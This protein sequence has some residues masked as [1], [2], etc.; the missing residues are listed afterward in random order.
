MVLDTLHSYFVEPILNNG[1]F[2]PVNTLVYAIILIIAVFLVYRL[3]RRMKVKIDNHFFLAII[4]FI[5][6]ASSTRVLHDAAVAGI[7]SPELNQ[8][9]GMLIFPTPGSYIITFLLAF[10]SLLIGLLFQ[11]VAKIPYWK[12]MVMIGTV[13]T[14]YN[15]ILL[16][17]ANLYA[18]GMIIGITLLATAIYAGIGKALTTKLKSSRLV[19]EI[20]SVFT[21]ENTCILAAHFLDASAT[22]ISIAYFGYLEQHFLPR[23]LF[24]M[25]GPGIMFVLKL[26]VVI[27]A[28]WLIDRYAEDKEFKT[29]LKIVVLILGLA[30][31]L[32]DTI[33]LAVP[34]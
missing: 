5:F 6:W 27:P 17:Y 20:S 15:I 7:L 28:L 18:A 29:L 3:L 24:P 2:N 31:G 19:K 16:P 30:P 32:R 26:V 22:F 11:K 8:F 10:S 25:F 21:S 12:V 13:L 4:P 23:S 34:V 14:I 1:W 33:R 9:Y